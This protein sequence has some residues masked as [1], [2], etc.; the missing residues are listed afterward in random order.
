MK[1]ILTVM[2]TKNGKYV[3]LK[4]TEEE[5]KQYMKNE[6]AK[7]REERNKLFEK[8]KKVKTTLSIISETNK[9]E[10]I[11]FHNKYNSYHVR[12]YKKSAKWFRPGSS[13]STILPAILS[14]ML[15]EC[16]QNNNKIKE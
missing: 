10:L 9:S 12:R 11:I 5:H 4:M 13:G 1:K 3:E 7:N 15:E 16:Y 14:K 6:M 8:M 2:V